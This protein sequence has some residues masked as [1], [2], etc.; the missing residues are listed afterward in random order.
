MTRQEWIDQDNS[1][2]HIT[3]TRNIQSII[4]NGLE[5]RNG[6]GVCVVRTCN[7]KI[8]RYICQMILLIDDDLDFSI[9]EI[10]PSIINLT[11]NEIL[12][13]NVEEITNPLQNYINRNSI[14]IM[15]INVIETF[16]ANLLGI[17]HLKEYE[18]DL[19]QEFNF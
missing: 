8:I 15:Q 11:A 14:P 1:F 5:N 9:I 6:R 4:N 13:D 17:L 16:K 7:L 2:Y 12:F 18:A 19:R 3:N 10:K